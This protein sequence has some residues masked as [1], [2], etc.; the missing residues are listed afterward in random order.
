MSEEFKA[1]VRDISSLGLGIVDHPSGKVFFV[2]GTWVGDEGIFR[3]ESEKKRYGHAR[4]IKLETTSPVRVTPSCPHHG[5]E[6]GSCGGCP[7]MMV[8]YN[9]QLVAKTKFVSQAM[10]RANLLTSVD[11]LKPIWASPKTLGF[12]NRAQFK[13]DGKRIGYV[14]AGSHEIAEIEDCLILNDK[15]RDLL[16]GLRKQLPSENWKASPGHDWN[17]IEIDDGLEAEAIKLNARQAFKQAD[18]DQNLRMKSWLEDKISNLSEKDRG[19]IVELFCGSGNFTE[20]LSRFSSHQTLAVESTPH[21]LEKLKDRDLVNVEVLQADIFL[22]ES[23]GK[24]KSSMPE[25]RVLVLD[26]PRIGFKSISKFIE[27]FPSLQKIFYIS[28]S[29]PDFIRDI[30]SLVGWELSELQPVD[31]FPHTPHLELL[32]ELTRREDAPQKA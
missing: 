28:C 26:P 4:L 23:W 6:F 15:C 10:K 31:Q 11:A 17:F 20:I 7:W 25:A 12:R 3:I 1:K 18:E 9:E 16:V 19:P 13:T 5:F 14:S 27:N 29:I 2:P 21:S 24:I 32:A 22:S 8:E 30:S